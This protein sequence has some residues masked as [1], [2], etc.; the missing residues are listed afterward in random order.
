[1]SSMMTWT[2]M[3]T[4]LMTMTVKSWTMTIVR[5]KPNPLPRGER[6]RN[7]RETMRIANC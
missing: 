5:R 6:R 3:K 1:M 2:M 7:A 4:A